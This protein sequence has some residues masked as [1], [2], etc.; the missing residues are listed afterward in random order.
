MCCEF[1]VIPTEYLSDNGSSFT[2]RDF[3]EMITNFHQIICFAVVVMGTRTSKADHYEHFMHND[4]TLS[5]TL[6]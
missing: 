6:A 3:T 5:N 2:S 4:A 1:D